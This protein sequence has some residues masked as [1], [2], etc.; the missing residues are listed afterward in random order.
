[1]Q[2]A[3]PDY[4]KLYL[5][6]LEKLA[7]A[8]ELVSDYEQ[9][10]DGYE[11]QVNDYQHQVSDYQHQV[12]GYQHQVSDYQQQVDGY[13]QQVNG[14]QQQVSSYE[15]QILLL[16]HELN[17]L[18]RKV[19]GSITDNQVQRAT[20]AGQ[21]DLFTLGAPAQLQEQAE[22]VLKQDIRQNNAE[23]KPR[24]PRTA[25]R[26]V[27][28]EELER[29]EVILDPQADLSGYHVMGEEVTEI[30]VHVPGYFK[31]KRI[32]RRKWALTDSTDIE[33]KG[34]LIAP[35]PSRTVRRGLFDESLLAQ[36]LTSKYVDHRVL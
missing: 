13:E 35:I 23:K 36:L 3:G 21:L 6:S 16:K 31:I 28:P 2:N 30:L 1:M 33:R 9:R 19:F 22:E 24:A 15:Q 32:I 8:Q 17:G 5:E 12:N 14:Y 26:M 20:Q 11:H 18:R 27:L 34:I 7:R 25:P 4:E 10:I 29:E